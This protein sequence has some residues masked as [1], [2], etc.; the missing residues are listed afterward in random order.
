MNIILYYFIF[1]GF[2]FSLLIGA[3]ASYIERKVTARVQ[4]RVGPPILQPLYDIQKL[5]VKEVVIPKDA[6]Y[7]LFILSPIVALVA[8]SLVA[9]IVGI[10]QFNLMHGFDG[11]VFVILYTLAIPAL[12]II[13]G[14]ASSGNPL[15]TVGA[16][17]EMKLFL[18]YELI[19]WS[20]LAVIIIKTGG[21][22]KLTSIISFQQA[23][24]AIADSL[25]GIIAF[26]LVLIAMQAK[27]GKVPFDIAEA[28]TEISGGVY[29]E[30]SGLL[31]AFYKMTHYI[32]LFVLPMFILQLFWASSTIW[33]FIAKYVLLLVIIILIENTNPRFRITQS[34]RI[35]WFVL[36]PLALAS[37]ALAAVGL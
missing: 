4:W 17:R 33:A 36:F 26:I 15:G 35:F 30:Y 32:M 37:I 12:F 18:G 5:F 6:N 24:G 22:I 2:L 14:A 23:H 3:L 1:P 16:S 25:S 28:E 7:S 21:M 31:L 9:T 34:I 27:L 13:L 8:A 29:I 19:F 20:G 10:I 11:D